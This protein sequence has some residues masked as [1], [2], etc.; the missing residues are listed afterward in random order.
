VQ[1]SNSH[2]QT[3]IGYQESAISKFEPS[4]IILEIEVKGKCKFQT[5]T[6]K[7][8]SAIRNQ[9]SAISKF[10]PSDIILEIEGKVRESAN[11]KLAPANEFEII[12]RRH[13]SS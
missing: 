11:F 6:S 10:Q 7:R 8:A 12:N 3:G 4:D 5:R 2:Q 13:V 9:P 1:I